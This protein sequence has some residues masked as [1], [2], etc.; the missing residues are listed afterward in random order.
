VTVPLELAQAI[1]VCH[2]PPLL[3]RV[4]SVTPFERSDANS[5]LFGIWTT[6]PVV[7]AVL[8]LP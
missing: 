6:W 4:E 5:R 3:N 7:I 1:P 8:A 2:T